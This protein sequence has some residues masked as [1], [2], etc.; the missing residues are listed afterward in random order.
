MSNENVIILVILTP[1]GGKGAELETLLR[2]MCA[3]SRAEEGC[4][5]YNLYRRAEGTPSFH[6]FECWRSPAALEAHRQTP[7]SKNF[8]AR[9]AELADGPFA[10]VFLKRVD[11]LS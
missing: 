5:V 1:R 7:H 8:R 2:G 10:P 6:L 4:I 3:P 9:V 11:A